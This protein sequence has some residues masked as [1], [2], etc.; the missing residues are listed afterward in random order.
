MRSTRR[1]APAG[2]TSTGCSGLVGA[3]VGAGAGVVGALRGRGQRPRRRGDR[4]RGGRRLTGQWLHVPHRA[5]LIVRT[6]SGDVGIRRVW[7]S[8]DAATG[9]GS[10]GPGASITIDHRGEITVVWASLTRAQE[11]H[12]TARV[13]AVFGPLHG[14]WAPARVIGHSSAGGYPPVPYYPRLAVAPGGAWA[15]GTP[16]TRM[17][18]AAWTWLGALRGTAS[19]CRAGCPPH[20]EGRSRSSTLTEPRTSTATATRSCCVHRR[21]PI[22]RPARRA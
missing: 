20:R 8:N 9:F 12:G 21:A 6:A 14:G 7:S 19:A 10:A 22:A 3:A 15:H 13:R 1:R 5:E 4:A 18:I 2:V 11:G 16:S 17:A